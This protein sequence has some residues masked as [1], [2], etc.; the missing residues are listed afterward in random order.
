[1]NIVL[2]PTIYNLTLTNA[3]TQYSQALP[4]NC[5]YF[6]LWCRTAYDIRFAFT[7]GIVATP[8]GNYL[9]CFAGM[10]YNSP[11]KLVI[12][13]NTTLYCASSTAGVIV[14]ILAWA[15]AAL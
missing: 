6:S 11:E 8:T 7:T 9:T 3:N 15:P 10:A 5:H 13:P 1:M 14:E 2:S 12:A 4:T